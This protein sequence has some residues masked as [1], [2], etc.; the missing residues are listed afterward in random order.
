MCIRDRRR[1]RVLVWSCPSRLGTAVRSKKEL[2]KMN[3]SALSP[4]AV[5]VLLVALFGLASCQPAAPGTN[6]DAAKTAN[7]NAIKETV[8]PVVIE[9]EI[10]KL[11]N[12]W[13]AAAQRKDVDTLRRILADDL[14]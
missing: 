11:E 10:V 2:G 13:A 12:E 5:L 14:V 4:K 1:S 8:N 7:A 3:R 6:R 9:A